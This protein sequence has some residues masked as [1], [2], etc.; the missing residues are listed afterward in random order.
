VGDRATVSR[1]PD[2][3]P[4]LL[5]YVSE[6]GLV[7]GAEVR[8]VSFAPFGGPVTVKTAAGA[9]AISRELAGRISAAG[10]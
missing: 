9:Q 1:V 4:E 8:I 2:A 10:S 7:P 6:L 3:D 5:R